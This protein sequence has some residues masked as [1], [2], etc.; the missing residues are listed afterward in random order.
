LR[1]LAD[2]R[3][4]LGIRTCLNILGLLANPA[5]PSRQVIGVWH[6]SL[7]EPVARALSL[8][9]AENAW[10]VYG[11][12][13]LDE[14]TLNGKTFVGAVKGSEVRPFVISPPDFGL[15]AAKID[16]LKTASAKESARIIRD[17][18]SG[19]RRDEARSLIVVNAAAA[20]IIGGLATEP[21]Q[22]ARL[23]ERSIDSGQAQN[24]LDRLVQLTSKS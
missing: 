23:A 20:L 3:S 14:I 15:K 6:K 8:L 21:M 9:K 24:K 22:A 19:K 17:V 5:S 13:G 7:I 18:F 4:S 12:D 11:S 16:H 10:V 2:V 1:R